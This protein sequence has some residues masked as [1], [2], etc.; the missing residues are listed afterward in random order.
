M[1]KEIVLIDDDIEILKILKEKIE[2]LGFSV[3]TFHNELIA[4]DQI[5]KRPEK[6]S[7]II[8]D[9]VLPYVDGIQIAKLIKTNIKTKHIPIIMITSRNL[10][11]TVEKIKN[12]QITD[13]IFKPF[14]FKELEKKIKEILEKNGTIQNLTT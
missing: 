1:D 9:F 14:E 3:E 4:L 10:K 13:F 12:A 6:I 8:L 5:N 7:L 11:D 2:D